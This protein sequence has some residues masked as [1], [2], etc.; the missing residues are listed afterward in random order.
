MELDEQTYEYL[1]LGANNFKYLYLT[2]YQLIPVILRRV[3]IR[4]REIKNKLFYDDY[5]GLEC[6]V[7]KPGAQSW[8]KGKIKVELNVKF[9]PDEPLEEIEEK[10][11]S[12][13]DNEAENSGENNSEYIETEVS[14]LD[15]LREKFNQENQ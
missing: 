1:S 15:D 5:D 10:E 14:P 6:E 8:Q 2:N 11:S 12:Q 7:I 13:S 4:N 9:Y 3:D